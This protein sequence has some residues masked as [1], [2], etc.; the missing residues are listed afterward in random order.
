MPAAVAVHDVP[1]LVEKQ[2]AAAYHLVVVVDAP[3]DLRVERLAAA[4]RMSQAQARSRIAAQADEAARRAAADV[5]LDNSG[6]P[7]D[8]LE[9][10]EELWRH[11]VAPFADNLAAGRPAPGR[12][13]EPDAAARRRLVA[14]VRAALGGRLGEVSWS[15]AERGVQVRLRGEAASAL[16]DAGDAVAESA[17]YA[18]SPV[19]PHDAVRE[20][21]MRRY[22]SCDPGRAGSALS[23]V[24]FT[25]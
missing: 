19:L 4:R 21:G 20:N 3:V 24:A 8:L 5:W 7:P 1:L 25:V 15:T 17:G 18:L 13:D 22:L 6:S 16:A 23:V 14:R 11:R 2:M 10:V 9:A 12:A